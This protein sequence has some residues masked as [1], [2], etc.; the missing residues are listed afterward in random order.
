[1]HFVNGSNPQDYHHGPPQGDFAPPMFPP[2]IPRPLYM[3]QYPQ[4]QPR[5]T[6]PM[7]MMPNPYGMLQYAGPVNPTSAA[8]QQVPRPSLG[9]SPTPALQP[10]PAPTSNNRP[11]REVRPGGIYLVHLHKSMRDS[12]RPCFVVF[13]FQ[14]DVLDGEQSETFYADTD[15]PWV[16][17][18]DHIVRI[19]GYPDK[20][21][22]SGKIVG[23][24]KWAILSGV[25]GLGSMMQRLVQKANNARTKA[26]ALEV[27]NTAVSFILQKIDRGVTHLISG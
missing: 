15:M 3:P 13:A 27:K 12:P 14:I 11:N 10:Q 4:P 2:G 22:L 18:R 16:E 20:V 7:S 6:Q 5:Y 1:M 17:F 9:P 8:N 19:L 25:E 23:E 21:Q 26:V 24:G